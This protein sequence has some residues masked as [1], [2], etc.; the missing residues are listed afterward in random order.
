MPD[1]FLKGYQNLSKSTSGS[2]KYT[3]ADGKFVLEKFVFFN[4]KFA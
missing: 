2:I 3:S 4:G 1:V